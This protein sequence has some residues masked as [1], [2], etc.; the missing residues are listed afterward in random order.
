MSTQSV[1]LCEQALVHGGRY[2]HASIRAWRTSWTRLLEGM[3]ASR[4]AERQSTSGSS[5]RHER[6]SYP[7]LFLAAPVN[8]T[9]VL[10][11]FGHVYRRGVEVIGREP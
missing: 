3:A 10:V 7:L 9:L 5:W 11:G 8:S 4:W 1:S 6:D 2:H